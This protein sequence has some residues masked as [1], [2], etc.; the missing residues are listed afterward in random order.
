MSGRWVWAMVVGVGVDVSV[1]VGVGLGAYVSV[2]VVYICVG[3]GN[4]CTVWVGVYWY[5]WCVYMHVCTTSSAGQVNA[6]AMHDTRRCRR[7]GAE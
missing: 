3:V 2:S 7:H 4:V 5:R 1:G 6:H